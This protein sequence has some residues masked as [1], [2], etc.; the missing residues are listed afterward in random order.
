MGVEE[1][2]RE[3]VVDGVGEEEGVKKEAHCHARMQLFEVSAMY[4]TLV[5]DMAAEDTPLGLFILA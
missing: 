4:R 3:G 1:L 2:V 5:T